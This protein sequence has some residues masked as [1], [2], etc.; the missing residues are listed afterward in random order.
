MS[1]ESSTR[2]RTNGSE[3]K[4]WPSAAGTAEEITVLHVD[5]EGEFV[6]LSAQFLPRSDERIEVLQETDPSYALQRLRDAD[7][8]IDCVVS[9]YNMPEMS[10]I[11][12]LE[13]VQRSVGDVPF[14]FFSS[15]SEDELREHGQR[16]GA[17][18]VVSK[19]GKRQFELLADRIVR[20]TEPEV[21][22]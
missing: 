14:I 5:D 2:G 15:Y 19:G 7:E 18:E 21:T 9:D 22:P 3:T 6:E 17:T 4:L 12:L 10:G 13:A 20:I 11:E 1:H 16:V 8:S